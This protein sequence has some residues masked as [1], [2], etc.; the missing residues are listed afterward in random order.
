MD[1]E[2]VAKR[3]A[4]LFKETRGL[5]K[6]SQPDFAKVINISKMH[7]HYIENGKR[8]PSIELYFRVSDLKDELTNG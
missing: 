6:L 3:T 8:L 1:R 5:T 7:V 2:K 4:R